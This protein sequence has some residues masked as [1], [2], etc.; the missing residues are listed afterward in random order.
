MRKFFLHIAVLSILG[1]SLF[2]CRTTKNLAEGERLYTGGELNIKD[3][4]SSKYKRELIR[5]LEEVNKPK[6][7]NKIAGM[8]LGLWAHQKVE[9]DEAG[10]YAKWVNKKIGEPPVLL[11]RV[12]TNSVQKLMVNR[13]ENLGYF[14]SN[15]KYKIIEN[16]K[17]GHIE[18]EIN[19]GNRLHIDS[20]YYEKVGEYKVD[21]LIT[22]Y[23]DTENPIKKGAPFLIGFSV[24]K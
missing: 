7:N 19:P 12:N 9:N 17:T 13:M 15:I 24:S 21:S 22:D 16:K 3:A 6:P 14:N 2:S 10:F 23:L 4:E 5:D 20:I 18:Y 8:R 11:D 1:A